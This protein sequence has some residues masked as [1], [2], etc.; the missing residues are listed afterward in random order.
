MHR[1]AF[2]SPA[3]EWVEALP[4]GNGRLGAMVYGREEHELIWLSEGSVWSGPGRRPDPHPVSAE[5]ARAAISASRAAI[6]AGDYVAAEDSLRLLQHSYPQSFQPLARLRRTIGAPAPEPSPQGDVVPER[7]GPAMLDDGIQ[8]PAGYARGLDLRAAV[9]WTRGSGVDQRTFVSDPHQV[10]VIEVSASQRPVS[11]VLDSPLHLEHAEADGPEAWAVLRAPDDVVPAYQRV[12][13]PV[14][15]A[16]ERRGVQAAVVL[17]ALGGSVRTRSTSAGLAVE[18]DGD[19]TLIVAVQTTFTELG[20]DPEPDAAGA[21]ARARGLCQTAA[22]IGVGRLHDE[23]A[24]AHFELY[25][26]AELR[27]GNSDAARERE[28]I[29]ADTDALV[30]A[31]AKGFADAPELV[32]LLFNYGRYLL[33]SSSRAGG[34]PANLQG[35]W[36]QQMQPP[37]SSNFTMN[38][39]LEMNYW[40]AE[41][42]GL[43]ECAEP[44]FDLVA[45]LSE[46]GR[47]P[48]ARIYGS[49]GW[50]SHHASD[51][52]AFADPMGD[53]THDP[54]W[55]FWPFA[56]VWLSSHLVDRITFTHDDA[57]ARRFW[58]MLTGA[59]RFVLDWLEPRADG[60]LGT[61]PSTSPENRF[62]APDGAVSSVAADS[63]MDLE[64][65]RNLLRSLLRAADDYGLRSESEDL[66]AEAEA[67][68]TRLPEIGIDSDG[69]LREW[70]HLDEMHDPHHR[71]IAHLVGLHPTNAPPTPRTAEAASR[72]LDARGD[73]GTGWSLAWK[74]AM[75]ARLHEPQAVG[76]LLDLLVRR[77]IEVEPAP[78]GGRWRGGLYRN[79]FSAHPP[80]QI[81]GNL[82]LVASLVECLVQSHAGYLELLPALPSGLRD[83]E[84]RGLRARG[85]LVVDLRWSAGALTEATITPLP[86]GAKSVRV[87]HGSRERVLDLT[88]GRPARLT[89]TGISQEHA[90]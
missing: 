21:V 71:H 56:G 19:T 4:I 51:I 36:N 45:A 37:W 14:R 66:C 40:L 34:T 85:G 89:F 17:R 24:A 30:D 88:T 41:T 90:S 39:N 70:A 72:S 61:S 77:N 28:A 79:L 31:A 50:V 48:A 32:A 47:E 16:E 82:G 26:R 63:T 44:L 2:A 76:R 10:L 80:F 68:L 12:P 15:W 33:I 46:R 6:A 59:A 73:E 13:D 5:T 7:D 78:G 3:A 29:V 86:E 1:L 58:P 67:A 35:L 20:R 11:F 81:D 8:R 87:V 60:S 18:V 57:A 9:A 75:R 69:L 27:L 65:S 55:A 49:S 43:A 52:W 53:G 62:V 83:G 22:G 38:I 23:H 84:V 74:M 42:T 64:L 25:D 54:A